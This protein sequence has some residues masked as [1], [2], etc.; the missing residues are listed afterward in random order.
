[1]QIRLA[2]EI[3]GVFAI[4]FL[5][6]RNPPQ[7]QQLISRQSSATVAPC[8]QPL[9]VNEVQEVKES[10]STSLPQDT[11]ADQ[12]SS[13]V[14][15]ISTE[16]D[17]NDAFPEFRIPFDT[18]QCNKVF[19]DWGSNQGGQLAK[20]YDGVLPRSKWGKMFRH[21]FGNNLTARH[22]QVCAFAWEPDP[23]HVAQHEILRASWNRRGIRAMS[24][25]FPINDNNE[26]VKFWSV[27]SFRH[28]NWGSTLL[29]DAAKTYDPKRVS[30]FEVRTFNILS[31]LQ[32]K[33]A[34]DALVLVKMDIEGLEHILYP[35]LFVSGLLC[36]LTFVGTELHARLM[37]ANQTALT[38]T[39]KDSLPF[40]AQSQILKSA[41]GPSCKAV[42]TVLDDDDK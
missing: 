42:V 39:G 30:S 2:F 9:S 5:V 20:L 31:F 41:F 18:L 25:P 6:L 15:L 29:E 23:F 21:Y 38:K 12:R 35:K 7:Q 26:M 10:T 36:K 28:T 13:S 34:S 11:I 16:T 14:P 8:L 3:I 32:H 37:T 17:P 27:R 1:M 33:I 40:A 22:E 19:L 4:L 24:F